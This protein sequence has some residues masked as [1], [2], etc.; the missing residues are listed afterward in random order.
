MFLT[1]NTRLVNNKKNVVVGIYFSNSQ[2]TETRQLVTLDN[3]LSSK[4]KSEHILIRTKK[5]SFESGF[6]EKK[7]HQFSSE[8]LTQIVKAWK[9]VSKKN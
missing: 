9:Y 6:L 5:L 2:L 3:Y 8:E 7:Y 4:L 1:G